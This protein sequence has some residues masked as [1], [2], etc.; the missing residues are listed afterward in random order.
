LTPSRRGARIAAMKRLPV[1]ALVLLI[2]LPA[3]A[4]KSAPAKTKPSVSA[5]LRNLHSIAV[6]SKTGFIKDDMVLGALQKHKELEEW[7]ITLTTGEGDALL[8]VDHTPMTF[9]YN[10]KMTDRATGT[11]L[12]AGKLHAFTGPQ[13]AD[14]IADKVVARIGEYHK[15]TDEQKKAPGSS[16]D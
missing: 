6:H 11:V 9:I 1:L 4:Q 16:P 3:F 5:L 14:D 10:Y 15:K 13:A 12:A 8:E 2:L 7:N